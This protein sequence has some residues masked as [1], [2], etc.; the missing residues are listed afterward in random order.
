MVGGD[1]AGQ[2]GEDVR[3][4]AAAK[5]V[6]KHGQDIVIGA[7]DLYLVA[8]QFLALLVE[9]F[10]GSFDIE[11]RRVRAPWLSAARAWAMVLTAAGMVSPPP[12]R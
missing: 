9:A 7:H 11:K 1:L 6:G 10:K 8:A 12:C 3:L 2:R 5:A 4:D